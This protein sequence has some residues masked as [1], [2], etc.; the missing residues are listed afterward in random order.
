MSRGVVA[1]A[2]ALACLGWPAAAHGAEASTAQLR[3]LASSAL[4]DPAALERLRAIDV[5]DGRPAR[6]GAALVGK[7]ADVRARLRAL[8]QAAP[9]A[10]SAPSPDGARER[11]RDVLKQQR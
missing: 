6:L 4:H 7:D 9:P 11:A 3:A 5:V 8:A 1:A 2:C 10:A